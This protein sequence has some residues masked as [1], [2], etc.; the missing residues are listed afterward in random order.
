[1][2]DKKLI[3]LGLHVQLNNINIQDEEEKGGTF[4]HVTKTP[5]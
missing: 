4:L 2:H 5:N 3:L 1:M